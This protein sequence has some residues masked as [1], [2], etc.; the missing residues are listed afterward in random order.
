MEWLTRRLYPVPIDSKESHIIYEKQ[1]RVIYESDGMIEFKTT[2]GT[3]MEMIKSNLAP[4]VTI[5]KSLHRFITLND[6]DVKFI[7]NWLIEND[8]INQE[9]IDLKFKNVFEDAYKKHSK[10]S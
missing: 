2:I 10:T 8:M 9:D 1:P 5:S 3:K 7:I 6:N 4:I